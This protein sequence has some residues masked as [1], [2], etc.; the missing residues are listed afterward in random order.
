M[1]FYMWVTDKISGRLK[2]SGHGMFK[3]V[4]KTFTTDGDHPL[5]DTLF[6]HIARK[7][8]PS[9]LIEHHPLWPCLFRVVSKLVRHSYD[10]YVYTCCPVNLR[11]STI[12]IAY[13]CMTLW[14][15]ILLYFTSLHFTSLHCTTTYIGTWVYTFDS[16]CNIMYYIYIYI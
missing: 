5:T 15:Y 13:H 2:G 8:K 12:Y 3:F 1:H 7:Y 16:I 10:S 14:H 11:H 6:L 9:Q 4:G